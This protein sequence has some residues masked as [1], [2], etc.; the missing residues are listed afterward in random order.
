[1]SLLRRQLRP[2]I[3]MTLVLCA[4]TGLLYPG[5]VTAIAQ[6]LFPRQAN[7]SLARN[8]VRVVGSHLIGQRFAQDGMPARNALKALQGL[9]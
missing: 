5:V 1:M 3:V 7:G 8:G 4:I 6:V 9:G 2:A